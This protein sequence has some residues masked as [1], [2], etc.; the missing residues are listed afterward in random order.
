MCSHTYRLCL[1]VYL[2]STESVT[3]MLKTSN[4]TRNT[5]LHKFRKSKD[6]RD[7]GEYRKHRNMVQ[8]LVKKA[9]EGYIEDQLKANEGDSKK[10]WKT[11]QSLGYSNKNRNRE[12]MVLKINGELKC[13]I[14]RLKLL[15]TLTTFFVNVA[16]DLVSELPNMT[17]SYSAFSENC[18]LSMGTRV[19][20]L[21]CLDFKGLV[22]LLYY[23]N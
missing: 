17:D 13:V 19:S 3:F 20:F 23:N 22:G 15:I 8:C 7:Y 2:L 10:T 12:P 9:K 1:S 18:N 14:I 16:H 21:A 6:A 4:C 11:L 5:S